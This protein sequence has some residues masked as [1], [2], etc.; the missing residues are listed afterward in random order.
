MLIDQP[1]PSCKVAYYLIFFGA[2]E[3]TAE[4]DLNHCRNTD[5]VDWIS[6]GPTPQ[7]FSFKAYITIV[8]RFN[9][10][11]NSRH[12]AEPFFV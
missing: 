10:N 9:S 1:I 7:F 3:L 11:N 5:A 2:A 12:D 8:A 4:M 6:R